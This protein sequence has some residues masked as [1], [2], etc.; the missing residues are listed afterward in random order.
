MAI[1]LLRGDRIFLDTAPLIYFFEDH[2]EFG[3][4]MAS[5]L[6]AATAN[7]VRLV[8]SLV[9]DIELQTGPAA[10]GKAELMRRYRQSL[11]HS[12]QFLIWPLDEA[13]ADT[14]VALRAQYQMKTPD[15][16]QLASSQQA[17]CRYMITNDRQWPAD[18]QGV[19]VALVSSL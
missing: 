1:E 9:S 15:A 7:G 2:P 18:V 11:L 12:G 8:T 19:Q 6:T 3:G 5:L 16:I 10:S 13:T 14:T 4:R 17:H